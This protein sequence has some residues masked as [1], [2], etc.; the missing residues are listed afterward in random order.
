MEQ[1]VSTWDWLAKQMIWT[2]LGPVKNKRILDFGS[3]DG[4]TADHYAAD[5]V[6]IAVEPDETMLEKRFST[7]PYQQICGDVS[8]LA[9]LESGSFDLILCHNVLEYAPE[10]EHILR[11]FSRLLKEDGLLSII[12]HNRAGRVMQMAVLLNNFGHAHALLDGENGSAAQFGTISYYED[13]D[14]CR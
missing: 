3:G 5:N 8:A 14:L 4:F 6:V 10:R 9:A 7:H 13:G 2:Q 1:I 11:E 12:K